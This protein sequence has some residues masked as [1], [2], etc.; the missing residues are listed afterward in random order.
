MSPSAGRAH[1]AD[2]RAETQHSPQRA[3][4][5][6]GRAGRA[7]LPRAAQR[8]V[9]APQKRRPVWS[10]QRGDDWLNRGVIAKNSPREINLLNPKGRGERG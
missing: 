1:S 3:A 4:A 8:P 5:L 2:P 6:P 9:G 10:R 7:A